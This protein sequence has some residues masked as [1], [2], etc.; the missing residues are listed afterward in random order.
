MKIKIQI[1]FVSMG[2]CVAVAVA[3]TPEPGTRGIESQVFLEMRQQPT[4]SATPEPSKGKVV[5]K[6]SALPPLADTF[7]GLTLWRMVVAPPTAPVRSR[8][9]THPRED[10]TGTKEW[11]AERITL[12]RVVHENDFIR[13]TF[14]SAPKGFLYVINRDV[15]ADGK[16]NE[17]ILIFPTYRIRGGRNAVQPG[18]PVQIP[19]PQ[20]HPGALQVDP[21]KPNQTGI[22]LITIVTPQP[23]PEIKI[24][25]DQQPVPEALLNR[26]EAQWATNVEVS[27]D[28]KL[29]G[30]QVTM[31]EQAAAADPSVAL[32]AK[33][34]LPVTLFHRKGA[35]QPILGKAL[36]RLAPK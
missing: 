3:Q 8:G 20:D 24:A 31:A 13:F 28:P 25:D 12:D 6:A 18:H 30:L 32:G 7:L 17:P 26:W 21:A 4:G 16:L 22:L 19:D 33:D 34:S 9:F 29:N 5:P 2:L 15:F 10:P 35:G 23:I 11:T 27:T 36:I 14:E 1:C